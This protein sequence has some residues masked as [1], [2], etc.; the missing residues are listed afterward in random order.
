MKNT[1]R[2]LKVG[3][4]VGSAA[5]FRNRERASSTIPKVINFYQNGDEFYLG[6]VVQ[7]KEYYEDK[8][9]SSIRTD[10]KK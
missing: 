2:A 1:G 5:F 6:I 9:F 8:S 3:A 10:S 7:T 4:K